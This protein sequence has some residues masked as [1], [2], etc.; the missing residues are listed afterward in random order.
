MCGPLRPSSAWIMTALFFRLPINFAIAITL[1]VTMTGCA[2]APASRG[3]PDVVIR[4]DTGVV[5]P[6]QP[7]SIPSGT[8][9]LNYG[10]GTFAYDIVQ[11]TLVTVGADTLGSL[12]DT[13][14]TTAS[15]T[16]SIQ[17]ASDSLRIVGTVDSLSVSSAR[18]SMGPRVLLTPVI[19]ELE[20]PAVLRDSM[21][22]SVIDS[23]TGT[24]VDSPAV[25]SSCD[26]MEDAARSLAR[27][28]LLRLP[29]NAQPRQQWRD[30]TSVTICRGGIPMMAT[31]ISAFE[32]QDVQPRG[33][34][35]V[36]PIVRRSVLT[37]SGTGTQGTRRITITGTGTSET[38]FSYELRGGVFLESQGQSI[39]QLRFETIQQ[40]EQVTQQSTSRV[41]RRG[42]AF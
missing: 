21:P 22:V 31:T 29:A 28:A 16:Y 1:G 19:V 41:R 14:L 13:L 23:V 10:T 9:P 24:P 3:T 32:I 39:L 40:T 17:R 25:L 12:Q 33:D 26:T 11:T 27:D 34:S 8:I 7:G 4:P 35:L 37:L 42:A 30:S 18:D 5:I 38:V 6:Q 15:L 36:V 2:S 20:P